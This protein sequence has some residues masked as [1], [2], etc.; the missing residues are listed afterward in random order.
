M[1]SRH[2]IIEYHKKHNCNKHRKPFSWDMSTVR[3]I[4]KVVEHERIKA[5]N[6]KDFIAKMSKKRIEELRGHA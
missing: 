3:G 1:E 2:E 5:L 4:K 6:N